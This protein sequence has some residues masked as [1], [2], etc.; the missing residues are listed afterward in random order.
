M[1]QSISAYLKRQSTQRLLEL[2]YY[3]LGADEELYQ[4]IFRMVSEILAQR[5]EFPSLSGENLL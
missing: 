2:W 5:G 4:N 3:Y 1:D